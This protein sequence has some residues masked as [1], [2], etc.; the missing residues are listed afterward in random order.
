MAKK[1][2]RVCKVCHDQYYFCPNCSGVTAAEK[3]KIMFCSKN[4][5]DVFQTCVSYDM[6]HITN[7]EAREKLSQLDLSK[8]SEFSE[9]LRA[10]ID[11]IMET[12][13]HQIATYQA[14]PIVEVEEAPVEPESIAPVF[15]AFEKKSKRSK[16]STIEI[17]DEAMPEN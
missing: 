3:Y 11:A 12:E 16:K 9:Q 4:C 1:L 10:E 5:R 17:D 13:A 15:D 2:N 7:D 6:N 14:L 8:K